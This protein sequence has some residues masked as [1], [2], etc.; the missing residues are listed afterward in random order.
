MRGDDLIRRLPVGE[1]SRITH[2]S[3]PTLRH[4]HQAGLLEPAEINPDTGYRYY[5]P[6]QVASAQVIRRLRDLAMPVSEIKSLLAADDI[7]A[8]NKVIT[9]HLD[10]MQAELTKT[11][12]AVAA[13]HALLEPGTDGFPVTHQSV[14]ATSAIAIS[15]D[16]QRGDVIDWWQGALGELHATL[17]AQRLQPTG[18]SG[19][20]FDSALYQHDRGL[21]VVYIPINGSGRSIGRV[22]PTTIPAAELAIADHSGPHTDIDITYGRLGQ[23]AAGRQISIDGPLREYYLVDAHDSPDP[24]DWKTR[25]GWP[26]FRADA[27]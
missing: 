10:A 26:I 16:V 13:L 1:F 18:P 21:A 5:R 3:V 6:D 9:A 17:A 8:R 15:Q 11:Q 12:A 27:T 25:I 24:E 22:E 2:L 23:Y 20:L 19:G 4:Y 7:G 14:P